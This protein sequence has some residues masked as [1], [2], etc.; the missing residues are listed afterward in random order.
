MDAEN[1]PFIVVKDG[2]PP[3]GTRWVDSHGLQS[4]GV[5]HTH[6]IQAVAADIIHA[7]YANFIFRTDGEPAIVAHKRAAVSEVRRLGHA[8]NMTPEET[9]V[10]ES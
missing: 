4:K 9:P 2:H 7:G 1:I 3:A 8:V 6:S 10:G 5:K